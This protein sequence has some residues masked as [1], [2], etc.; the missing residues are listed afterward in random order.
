MHELADND[1]FKKDNNTYCPVNVEWKI[2]MSQAMRKFLQ[3]KGGNR[4]R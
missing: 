4:V 3:R 2:T 1:Y